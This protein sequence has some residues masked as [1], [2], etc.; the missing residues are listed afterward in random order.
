[1]TTKRSFL[2]KCRLRVGIRMV[3]S[4]GHSESDLLKASYSLK[5]AAASVLSERSRKGKMGIGIPNCLVQ[6]LY[7]FELLFVS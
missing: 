6:S 5:R 4:A 7:K 2:D 1:M 3:V